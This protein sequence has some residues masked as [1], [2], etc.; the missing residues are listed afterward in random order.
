MNQ[1]TLRGVRRERD[2]VGKVNCIESINVAIGIFFII[3]GSRAND[4]KRRIKSDW[5]ADGYS[6]GNVAYALVLC[7][8]FHYQFPD[9]ERQQKK[10]P[11]VHAFFLCASLISY[12]YCVVARKAQWKAQEGH[13]PGWQWF[14]GRPAIADSLNLSGRSN[15]QLSRILIRWIGT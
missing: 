10:V 1:T 9:K 15:S 7:R 13:A 4:T 11:Q 2:G 14:I 6:V 5:T 3:V 8:L 12:Y